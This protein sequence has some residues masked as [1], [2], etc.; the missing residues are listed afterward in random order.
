MS[1]YALAGSQ[2][3][4]SLAVNVQPLALEQAL[5]QSDALENGTSIQWGSPIESDGFLEHKDHLALV[6][7]GVD[8]PA[9]KVP[10]REFWPN[11]GPVWDAIGVAS[12]GSS[13]FVEAKA[14]IPEVNSP[15]SQA[16]KPE[17]LQLIQ[18]SLA[19]AKSYFAPSAKRE[20]GDVFY[21]YVNRLAHHYWLTKMNGHRSLLIFLYFLNATDMP[22][23]CSK[24]EWQG[25]IQLIHA[26]LGLPSEL[27]RYGVFDVFLDVAKLRDAARSVTA[28]A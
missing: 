24:Q 22:K 4:L 12:D 23:P 16:A 13:I 20:W 26:V 19:E 25:A 7:A 3:W 14:H 11:G 18:R 8:V 10:L 27:R 6:T 5:V 17:S 9:L 1:H 15:A 28:S 2:K 21:Q